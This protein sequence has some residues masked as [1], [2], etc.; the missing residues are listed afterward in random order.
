MYF[1]FFLV[2]P[3]PVLI[4]LDDHQGMETGGLWAKR[5]E[6]GISREAQDEGR[7]KKILKDLFFL[8]IL[9]FPSRSSQNA[10]FTSFGS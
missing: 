6:R 9:Y 7:R 5:G 4:E 10:A 1:S 3:R 2:V 8:L